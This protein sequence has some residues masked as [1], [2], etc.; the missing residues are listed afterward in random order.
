MSLYDPEFVCELSMRK[1]V[2]E[3]RPYSDDD[4]GENRFHVKIKTP[5]TRGIPHK[6][7]SNIIYI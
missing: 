5:R 2:L 3:N 4:D 1:Y 7:I 6:N